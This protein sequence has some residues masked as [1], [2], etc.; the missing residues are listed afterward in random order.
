MSEEVDTLNT[1]DALFADLDIDA[2]TSQALSQSEATQD[3]ECTGNNGKD[4]NCQDMQKVNENEC[5]IVNGIASSR[6]CAGDSHSRYFVN[7]YRNYHPTQ[8]K[9]KKEVIVENRCLASQM[10]CDS[11]FSFSFI[12]DDTQIDE[13]TSQSNLEVLNDGPKDINLK[14]SV[15]DTQTRSDAGGRKFRCTPYLKTD[16]LSV[17]LIDTQDLPQT[18]ANTQS[19]FCKT[20]ATVLD[21]TQLKDDEGFKYRCTPYKTKSRDLCT[22][23]QTQFE[24]MAGT[25]YQSYLHESYQDS[26]SQV[27]LTAYNR[28][29]QNGNEEKASQ[30]QPDSQIPC[31]ALCDMTGVIVESQN[32]N[33][34]LNTSDCDMFNDSICIDNCEDTSSA[35]DKE[36][37]RIEPDNMEVSIYT[38]SLTCTKPSQTYPAK[39]HSL[40]DDLEPQ[41]EKI[42]PKPEA[43][44]KSAVDS[45]DSKTDCSKGNKTKSSGLTKECKIGE[46]I[47]KEKQSI[48]AISHI[49]EKSLSYGDKAKSGMQVEAWSRSGLGLV[50]ILPTTPGVGGTLQ[51]RIKKRLQ[52]NK[53]QNDV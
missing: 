38:Q 39:I 23:T 41:N 2:I 7:K 6:S 24:L 32:K 15:C 3:T 31:T 29:S 50:P 4:V 44:S 47:T 35:C 52:V 5:K 17:S 11:S 49:H 51:D 26:Q 18:E 28:Q 14:S 20:A 36:N 25:Q 42:S 46:D 8:P 13:D 12:G 19:Q 10:R 33:C 40:G 9:G 45:Y 34:E 21:T 37:K 16:N 48:S 43:K 27:P 30:V 22:Q 1:S 53:F